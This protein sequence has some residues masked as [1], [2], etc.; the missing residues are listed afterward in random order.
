MI[1]YLLFAWIFTMICDNMGMHF[2]INYLYLMLSAPIASVAGMIGDLS[3]SIIKRQ[4]A[5][6]DFGH[7]MP[8]HG[9]VLDRFDSAIFAVPTL[10]LFI[11]YFPFLI[12]S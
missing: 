4:C 7:I 12:R 10:Y 3:F 1:F 2:Q 8:G 9:G 11:H 5:V 6:K